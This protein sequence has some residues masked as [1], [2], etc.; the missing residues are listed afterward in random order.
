MHSHGTHMEGTPEVRRVLAPSL[1]DRACSPVPDLA[2]QQLQ[3]PNILTAVRQQLLEPWAA[4]QQ[5]VAMGQ[6]PALP[7]NKAEAGSEAEKSL[8]ASLREASGGHSPMHEQGIE[9]VM[10]SP[11]TVQLRV[12]DKIQLQQM[13]STA[14]LAAASEAEQEAESAAESSPNDAASPMSLSIPSAAVNLC[15][16]EPEDSVHQGLEAAHPEA[17]AAEQE[18][19]EAAVLRLPPEVIAASAD[20]VTLDSASSD[21]SNDIMHPS[22]WHLQ[23]ERMSR[24]QQRQWQ[25]HWQQDAQHRTGQGCRPQPSELMKQVAAASLAE[26]S[27][28]ISAIFERHSQQ[29]EPQAASML[30]GDRSRAEAGNSPAAVHDDLHSDPSLCSLHA[31]TSAM[32]KDDAAA[33]APNL[34]PHQTQASIITTE[35]VQPPHAGAEH[36]QQ[37]GQVWQTQQYDHAHPVEQ[38]Q[39]IMNH[40][41]ESS[42]RAEASPSTSL[43]SKRSL[44]AAAK[45]AAESPAHDSSA[46]TSPEAARN[47]RMKVRK[48]SGEYQQVIVHTV[49]VQCC[50]CIRVDFL[51]IVNMHHHA[52]AS[53]ANL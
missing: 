48:T 4:Q 7:A 14:E 23:W 16:S 19:A 32:G 30:S 6:L 44:V 17:A 18:E 36:P 27:E 10:N 52:P 12:L 50:V 1:V 24:Q 13:H 35:S 31:T 5:S 20:M 8:N 25:Q 22:E 40:Q 41:H 47:S 34:P 49:A 3:L 28:P 43:T 38:A 45:S 21:D 37:H 2:M 26:Q 33:D 42:C 39:H 15:Y 9:S 46:E 51:L 29:A 53:S 11:D